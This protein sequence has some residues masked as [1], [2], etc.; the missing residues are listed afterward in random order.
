M[1]RSSRREARNAVRSREVIPFPIR[2]ERSGK[3]TGLGRRPATGPKTGRPTPSGGES[4]GARDAWTSLNLQGSAFLVTGLA[5]CLSLLG[6]VMIFSASSGT[7]FVEH[8]SS[9][10]YVL[11]QLLWL[12]VGIA[13]LV[14]ASRLGYRW[15]VRISPLL[16]AV[17]AVMLV[18]VLLFGKMVN[19]SRRFLELGPLVL[20]PS[21]FAKLSLVLY[22]CRVLGRMRPRDLKD[23][24]VPFMGSAMFLAVLVTKEPD[25]GTAMILILTALVLLFLAGTSA[26]HLLLI[27]SLG[28]LLFLIS[29]SSKSY[30]MNRILGVLD[31]WKDPWGTGYQYIQSMIAF[32]SG[33]LKG[34][35][36]GMGRQKFFYLPNAHTDFIF[37]IIGEEWGFLGS[38]TILVLFL[39]LLG[40][41]FRLASKTPDRMGR[42]VGGSLCACL[43][44]QALV[45]MGASVAI[46][47]ITGVTL[48]FVSYGGSSLVTCFTMVGLLVSLA[49]DSERVAYQVHSEKTE[50][51]RR[52]VAGGPD[53]RRHGRSRPSSYRSGQGAGIA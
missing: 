4:E 13:F 34:L 28:G 31:P 17:S 9:Y 27:L 26:R 24:F 46:F 6:V 47:P 30:Q 42:L 33:G 8:G 50:R 14:L 37:S 12:A 2:G 25:L 29:V 7:A 22:G 11:R 40:A 49:W 23:V 43:G 10:Y 53:G 20:Q 15:M 35:G 44:I 52:T 18:V 36:L 5:L 32:G 39:A 16:M 1:A 45:N 51:R 3:S 38:A 21:E 48:P 19:G 41:G